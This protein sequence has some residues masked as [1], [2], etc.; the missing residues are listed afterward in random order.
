MT[1]AGAEGTFTRAPAGGWALRGAQAY[2]GDVATGGTDI[3]RRRFLAGSIALGL[4]AGCTETRV[5]GGLSATPAATP[6]PRQSL[7]HD[8]RTPDTPVAVGII[9]AGG[10]GTKL[11]ERFARLPSARVLA[12]CDPDSSRASALADRVED[13][14]DARP[15]VVADLRRVLDDPQIDAVVVATPHHWHALAAI[16]A[17]QAGKHLYLEKPATHSLAEGPAILEAWQGSGLVVEVG[18]QRRSHP[19]VQEAIADLHSGEIGAVLLARCFSWKRRPSIGPKVRGRWPRTLDADLWFGPREVRRPSRQRFHYDWHWFTDFGNGGLGNN[20]VHRLDVARWGMGLDGVGTQVLSL[21]G[22]LGPAD[23]GQTPNTAL[24]VVSFGDVAVVHDLRGLP[25]RTMPGMEPSDEVTF[26]GGEG[27]IVVNRTGGRLVDGDGR[28]VRTYGEDAGK[29]D[30]I[31]RHIKGFL[32]AVR[33]GDPSAVA[34]GLVEGVGAA[35]MCHGPAAAHASVA[36]RGG[37]ADHEEVLDDLVTL[38]GPGM[39][40][41][42]ED[43]LAHVRMHS[44]DRQL[45]YSGVRSIVGARVQDAP[46]AFDYRAGFAVPV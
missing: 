42:A 16:W 36:A 32:R 7:N 24:T 6:S 37:K 34:V 35:S 40:R 4:L 23:A 20:G 33:E 43:F 17:M 13:I 19:G 22:R 2:R 11:A 21:G 30:P 26:V 10:H 41:P 9:G 31:T 44:G 46:E 8:T 28:T 1:P 25:T 45:V 29:V 38:C 14:A 39:R 12:V 18:T 27:S 3:G 5:R 15:R